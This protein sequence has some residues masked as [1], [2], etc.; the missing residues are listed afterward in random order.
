MKVDK[1]TKGDK[2]MKEITV[3]DVKG[4]MEVISKAYRTREDFKKVVDN[5]MV[6]NDDLFVNE[7]KIASL[8]V[9]ATASMA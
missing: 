3:N 2:K 5:L 9:M 1:L 8:A 6:T 4:N 7:Y